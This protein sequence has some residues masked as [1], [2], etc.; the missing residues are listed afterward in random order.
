[1]AASVS[2]ILILNSDDNTSRLL[3]RRAVRHRKQ[4][5]RTGRVW[6][7]FYYAGDQYAGEYGV[8]LVERGD[9]VGER[10]GCIVGQTLANPLSC[11]T[12]LHGY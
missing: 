8:R 12:S 4:F 1:M 7:S 5:D 2:S 9:G 10:R 3:Y 11:R 6:H